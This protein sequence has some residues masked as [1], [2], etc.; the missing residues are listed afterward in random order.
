MRSRIENLWESAAGDGASTPVGVAR[1]ES[2]FDALMEAWSRE[3]QASTECRLA[4][5]QAGRLLREILK[6][7]RV[8]IGLRRRARRLVRVIR[9]S[10]DAE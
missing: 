5:D 10:R 1:P 2:D 9:A 6:E 8:P 7:D 4:L 3:R